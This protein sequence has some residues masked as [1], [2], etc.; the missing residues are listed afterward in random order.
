MYQHKLNLVDILEHGILE[1]GALEH[2]ILEH[3]R[4]V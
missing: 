3:L 1:Y 2:G 4:I